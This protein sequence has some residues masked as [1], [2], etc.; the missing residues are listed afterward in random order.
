MVKK[1]ERDEILAQIPAARAAGRAA[2]RERWWPVDVRYEPATER[3]NIGLRDGKSLIIPRADIAG[4]AKATRAQLER[5][6]LAGEAIRWDEL[7]VDVSVPGLLSELL[8]P[9]FSTQ[10]SGRLGGKV[11]SK[12]KAAA[13][14]ANG[15]RGGRR[16]KRT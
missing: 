16:R 2:Q 11:R 14:R 7:D 5:V 15:S 9:R 4:L 6:E 10:A 1:L 3:V 8:G 13:A 12:A